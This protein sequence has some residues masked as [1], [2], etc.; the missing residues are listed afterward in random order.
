MLPRP[1]GTLLPR[2]L[3]TFGT[4]AG[5]STALTQC[6]EPSCAYRPGSAGFCLGDVERR[7]TSQDRTGDPPARALF[8]PR[9][10]SHRPPS[11]ESEPLDEGEKQL[12]ATP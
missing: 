1:S 8:R 9:D 6:A 5:V 10:G 2:G 12:R 7:P 3:P 4:K 11:G